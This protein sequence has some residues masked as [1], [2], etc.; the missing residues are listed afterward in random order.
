MRSIKRYMKMDKNEQNYNKTFYITTAIH[1]ANAGPH[2]G[3]AYE[4]VLADIIARYARLSG[5]E[6]FFLS[7]TDEHGQ[8]IVRGAEKANLSPQAFVDENAQKFKDLYQRLNLS[9]DF[10]IRTSDQ[11]AHWSGA[12][13]LWKELAV[14]GDI[15]KEMYHGLYCVGCESFK[16]EKDLVDGKCPAHDEI[17]EE[18]E[19]ENYFFRA[20]KYQQKIK[21]LIEKDEL[22]V[23]P[24]SAKREVLSM[25]EKPLSDPSFSRPKG[26]SP[27]GIPVPEDESQMMYVWCD[28]LANYISA[29]GYGKEDESKYQKFWPADVQVIGKDI[30]RFHAIFWP[31]M[32]LSAGLPLPKNIL[33]HGHVTSGGRKMSKTLG[34]VIDPS[35]IIKKYGTDPFRHYLGHEISPFADGDF[36][37]EKFIEITNGNLAHGIGNLFSRTLAMADKYFDGDIAYEEGFDVPLLENDSG[38]EDKNTENLKIPIYVDNVILPD[39][40]QSMKSFE[41]NHAADSIWRFVGILD[42]YITD[43]EPFKLIKTDEKKTQQ[44]LW[45]T[46]FGLLKIAEM[47]SPFMPETAEKMYKALGAENIQK[48]SSDVVFHSQKLSEPLFK[49]IDTEKNN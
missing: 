30:L 43:Y 31:A 19:E 42:G 9:N 2:V 14:K 21:E 28:A 29:L 26:V 24:N 39:Y 3:H 12:Q 32:L 25:L 47:V 49:K 46:M 8:K 27:W 34:N 37:E 15:Y 5:R 13:K 7:G 16:T 22:Q 18:I 44:V 10:F 35:E 1:Y 11:E 20:S 38:N 40:H 23:L 36:T 6:T 4:G 33:V 45:N 41:I 48:K 17:P